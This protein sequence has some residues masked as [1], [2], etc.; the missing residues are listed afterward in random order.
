MPSKNS[1][2]YFIDQIENELVELAWRLW[3]TLGVSGD[4]PQQLDWFIALEELIILTAVIGNSDPRL[5]DEALD[6]CSRFHYFV[7]I[8]RLR[9][10]VNELGE[11][12]YTPFSIFA[13]T[14][15]STTQ[16]K[17]PKL[18][19]AKPL[20]IKFSEKSLS[21][22]CEIPALIAF[23]MRALFGIGAKAD[24][25]T[26]FLTSRLNSFTAAD[27]VEVGYNKRTIADALDSFV[28]SGLLTYSMTR[29]QK[30]YALSKREQLG[31]LAGELPKVIPDWR[32]ILVLIITLRNVIIENQK[33]ST[34]VQIVAARNALAKLENLL[35]LFKI[36][37]P[38]LPSDPETYWDS[39][40]KWVSDTVKT[41]VTLGDFR[42]TILYTKNFEE[43]V[44]TLMQ[45]LYKLDDC[46][47]G[48]EFIMSC[49]MENTTRHQKIFKESYQMSVCYLY[50]LKDRL[51]DLLK[52]PIHQL[53]DLKLSEVMYR[54][55]QEDRESFQEFVSSL[56]SSKE[57]SNPGIALHQYKI[58]EVELNKLHRFIYEIK[59]RLKELYAKQ[60]SVHLLTTSTYLTK[61]H[62]VL[63]LFS[64][65]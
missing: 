37:P 11:Q 24:L 33:H 14:L 32:K 36:S 48:L 58:L 61:R 49:V 41:V 44:F 3:C 34:S 27:L 55:V 2:K 20:K 21:P 65:K 40:V 26:F 38:Q 46:V 6:W 23:R 25:I 64:E 50:E 7:S 39:F 45:N 22:R 29:N 53:M 30:K 17:W 19:K 52:F 1:P 51:D 42:E 28:Q 60:T 9:T 13:E 59:E 56:P 8:S 10:L 62:A 5:R 4:S 15:N 47:D 54:F 31:N 63:N 18:A 57:I 16:T 43:I 12:V 35:H